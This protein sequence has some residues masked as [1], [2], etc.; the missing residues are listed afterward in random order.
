MASSTRWT[1]VW[2]CLSKLQEMVMDR[3]TWR[4]VIHGVAKSRTRLSDWTELIVRTLT[5]VNVIT[6][7]NTSKT[8]KFVGVFPYLKMMEKSNRWQELE[9]E[10]R[11]PGMC[12]RVSLT[13]R[14]IQ[15][16]SPPLMG[17][18][19]HRKVW[20]PPQGHSAGLSDFPASLIV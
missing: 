4:A 15:T 17:R 14:Q 11:A 3:E 6:L 13:T 12:L 7:V 10:K 8:L 9:G 18:N 2:A 5:S 20:W 1:W 19:W 16:L